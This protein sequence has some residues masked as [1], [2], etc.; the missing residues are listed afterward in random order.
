M[1]SQTLQ[2]LRQGVWAS[3]TGGWYY[4]PHQS[5]F[6]N[7]LHLYIWL[8]LLCFPFTLYMALPPTM[9]IV[10]I[11]C[12]VVAG[13]FLLLKT[14]NYRLHHAL[15]E[16]EVVEHRAKE[17]VSGASTEEANEGSTAT[18]QEDRNGPGDPGGGI[19]MADFIREETPPVD[20][21]SRNSY[22]GMDS[23]LQMAS[24]QGPRETITA[25]GGEEVG[26]RSDDCRLSL[27]QSS[28][29]VQDMMSDLKM[30]C[31]VSNHS[32]ASMQPSTSLGP[33]DL[34]HDPA[35]LCNSASHPISQSLS[36]CDTEVSGHAHGLLSQSVKAEPRTRGL[37][38]TSSSAGSA[39]P[40]PSQPSA[41][42][43]LY[44]PPRRGGL[45]PVCELEA[46]RPHRP[47][48]Q[49]GEPGG[50]EGSGAVKLHHR[51]DQPLASTSGCP[52][53]RY[54]HPQDLHRAGLAR[55]QSREAG[56]GGSGLY[57][58]DQGGGGRSGVG[59]GRGGGKVSADS[60]R[61]L[62][63]RSSGSTES[64]C[65]GTDR[66]TNSTISSFHS[67]Q[68]SS[69]HVESLLSLSGDEQRGTGALEGGNS[70]HGA[71]VDRGSPRGRSHV[72]S[73]GRSNVPSREANKNP[74]ANELTAKQSPSSATVSPNSVALTPDPDTSCSCNT[75]IPSR[76]PGN[77]PDRRVRG[78][79]DDTRPKSAN[80]VQRTSSS[81]GVAQTGGGSRRTGK[82]RASSFDASRHRDYMSLRGTAKP[83]SA[84]FAGGAA[85][86]EEWSDGSE[87]S[88]ASSLQSTMS[89]H[90]ST[91]SSS[92]TTSQSCH[93]PEGRYR[94][95][96]A[97]HSSRHAPTPSTSQKAPAVS[98]GGGGGGG[99]AGGGGR[100][101]SSR[102]NPSTGS[103]RTHARVLSLDSG[104]AAAACL[105]DPHRLGAPGTGARPLTTSKSDLEAK[106]GEVLDAASLL[107][108]AS[109]L[110]TVTRSRNSLPSQT[111][112]C[113]E[114][115]DGTN[116]GSSRAP[117]SEDAVTFRRERSTFRRQAVRRRHNAGS[118]PTPPSS[119]IGSP[120]SLQEALSQASQPSTSQLKGLP[121]RTPSQVTVL[122]ASA[123]LLARNGSAHL[124]GSQD[125]A[126]TVGTTSLQ[127]DFGKQT[128]S[129]YE[130]GGCDMSL[131][132]FEPATRRASNNLW[133]TDSHLSSATSVRVYPHDLIRLNRLLT[134]DPELLEQQDVDLSPELQDTPLGPEDPTTAAAR[135]AKHYYRLWLLP[136]LWV[137]L[138]FDRLT[139]LA[140]FDRNRELLENVLAVVLAV[141]VAFLGSILLVN[142]FFTDIWVFQFCL[143]IASCQYSLL[144]S[145]QPD[146]SS[147]RHGHNRIIAYSRPVY[148]CLCCGLIWALD[149]SSERTSSARITLYGV[150]L[151]SSLVLASARDLV[152]VFTLCFPVVFFVGLLPQ[153]NTFV[154][155]L[156]EQLDIHVFG[157]NASTSLLSSVYSVGR[158]VVTVAL[159][160]ALCYGALKETWEP[161]HIPVLFSVFCGLLVAVSYHLSRQSSDPSVLISL[162]QSKVL[163][164]LK[165]PNPEDPLSEVQ[166][167]L[168]E[169]L[170]GS[171]NERLH[172][173]LIVCVVIA[174]LYFA[175]HVSTMFI[176]LQPF[177]SYVLYSLLGAVGLLT[178]HVLP[179][180]RQQLPWYCFS[181][182]LLKTKEYYQFEVRGAAH[183]MWF[184]KLHVW[185]LFLEKNVLYPLVIL[186]EMSGSA[187]EL[188]S[189]RKL[190]TEVGAL[191]ITVAGLKLLRSSFSSPTYQYVTVLFTVLF[192]TFDYRDLSETL[193][194]DLFL[195]SIVFSK[196]WELFYKLRFVYTYI[197]PW[198]ITWGSAFH[199]FA[200]PFAVPHSA[201]LFVQAIISS[202]FSTPLNP[203]LGSAIFITSYVR[204][205]KFWE[206]D[207]NTK[208]VDHSNTRL[209]SQLDR[210]PGSD[211]NNL[212]SIFYEHLT[213]SLQHSLCGDLLLGRWGNYGTGDCFIL[214]SD[215]LNA[216]VHLVEI[217]NGL[218]TYQLRGLEFRGTYCQQ[219]EVEA[220]TEGVEEDESCCCCEPGHLPH[221]LSFNAAF[222]QRWL[223]WEVLVTKYVLEGYS[224]TDN[225]AASMLQVFDLRRILTTYYVKGI[226]YYV[227]ESARLDE[228]LANE[229]MR[230]GLKA[231]GERNYVDL[232]P[233]FNPNID[234]DYDHRLAG[235]SRDSFCQVYLAWIQY[236]NSR[237]AKPLDVEK[238][239]SL[240]LLCF[241][242]CVLGRRALGTAAHHMSS[243]LES[244][245]HGLH[246]LFKGD[247]R[248]S[249]VRDEWIF[250]D[251]ELLKKVV[252]PGIR[253]SLKLHQDHFTSPDE[254]D[255]PVVLFEAISSHQQNLVIAHEG[256]PAWRSAVLS[257]SPSLLALRHVLDEGTNEYKIIMLNRRYLS[258]RVI[259]VNKECVRGLWAG[260]QQ[261][262]VFFRNR[263]PERGSIQNAK[264]ALRNMINSS[265]DQPIGYPIY[266][267]P[268]TTSY[269]DSHT[270]LGHILGGPISMGNIR[271]FVVSTW[272]RLRK[273]CGAGCNSGGNI[274]DPDGGGVSCASGNGSGD[275]QPSSV[276]Q[277]GLSGTA[278]PL[279]HLPHTMG[280]D[281]GHGRHPHQ[282]WGTSQSSQSVQSGLV[283]H[284]P[285]RAS[286]AS[287][288][289]SYR[290]S[291][292]RHSSLRTSA[293]GL[294][295][296]RRSSTSQLSLRTLPT[297]LQLRLGSGSSSDPAGPSASLSSHSI[298]LC[299]RHTLVGLLGSDGLCG[300]VA[301]PLGQHLHQHQHNPTLVSV[302]RDDI[303]YRVQIMDVSQVLENINLSKRKELQ[304]PDETLRLRAGRSCWRDW[305]PLEGMEGHVIHRWVPCSRDLASRSHIDKTIL[306]VQVDDKLVPIIETGVIELGAE[307]GIEI[308]RTPAD[309][310]PSTLVLLG[311][312]LGLLVA[313]AF[314][315]QPPENGKNWVVIVAGSNGWYN[316]RHQADACHAYQIVHNNGVPDEQIVVMMYDDL[317]N[318]EENPTPGV[319][320]N[321]P[322]GTDVYKGVPKDYI[323]EAVTSQ[324]FLA[325]LKGESDSIKGGSGKVLKSG[326]NDHVFVYF[327]D[328]GA[329]GLLAFPDDELHVDDLQAT[330]QYMRQNK[331]YKKMVFYIE[332]C[333]SG[334]MMT[335]LPADID[336]YAT[337]ASNSRESSYACYYDEKR[338]T[339]LGD[340]YSV[341]WME[342]SD[343]EDLSKETLLKQFKIVK[344]HT[345]TSHVQQFGNKTL[346]HM[347]VMAFQGNARSNPPSRPVALQAVADPDLTPGPDVPLAIL[348]RKLM[349]TND[350]TTARTY[351][352]AINAELKV[353]EMLREATRSIVLKVT[354]DEALTQKIL[355]SQLDLTQ[356]QCYKAAVSHYKTHCFNW[357]TTQYEYALR[358]L[359]A[360]VNLCEEGYPTDRILVAMESVCQFN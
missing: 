127:D 261:E 329:P 251:M 297:S 143:V 282:A 211:D 352:G 166:D 102:R 257:N 308:T 302:R 174:V 233:T 79:K 219:R 77:D 351:L 240:V 37:P 114:P 59:G 86:E 98:E 117:G 26:K 20:C 325:V 246:A 343:V 224:I 152:I 171:V 36:S 57:Q 186:N 14:V 209:A 19:E 318:S 242:L 213:R 316:Y 235:I 72:P 346:A 184:E 267:S 200:Q 313:N 141:L 206:R 212:N 263:N 173:D 283:R 60:L 273:G 137:S 272:H 4:D 11:Y 230:E 3:I 41:E 311:L 29:Q 193:L 340:W 319:L 178:H 16:G 231:C 106:E 97:K 221:I 156:F 181:Q 168:P 252:V 23:G 290:Y 223:A 38:R 271:N 279:A 237:R 197:A 232:D 172:S 121:S 326:P 169:K 123:S 241:G 91:D 341:N 327:T 208:R 262:L 309:M 113:S 50:V 253:M 80:L 247:F 78:Q 116:T 159:L 118:N 220:I 84:V 348:K 334:S 95:L 87:L 18:R 201:M 301:D 238:D 49:A 147:P 92:S 195:M 243:N 226:I 285:A 182:P 89:Q 310:F 52:T 31:L 67:E 345:N 158:S 268:L 303:S 355:S 81:S 110:E 180:L 88:C 42:F 101:C 249:S 32:F 17:E 112:F 65:S 25:K 260:Q 167:P 349:K 7:A 294:E 217:G 293:T 338:D 69:T 284:S 85:G 54:K 250:A 304:W 155:Y 314:P 324:N 45:D 140:L 307:D 128:P 104:T 56:E 194:L 76:A 163:P 64:Y 136:Y 131:V 90:F 83:R 259:K 27:V 347:K 6:V 133:D 239:S 151:T 342:D 258:F 157:G 300:G 75:D 264:Q 328:H 229:T 218:V 292:S 34:S 138:H 58:V 130:A 295:P 13:L 289:S 10:G 82:K 244:F 216:L 122:S 5:T 170:R 53:D 144:K 322:N 333:E 61:S 274:E 108:R 286:V 146:S 350:I 270:Q 266:V 109:Q 175:I 198:Q 205:V 40:D 255:E 306:L 214:A 332:A 323:K 48:A 119:L 298:P 199:A 149:Y 191:M 28:S 161:Q 204:P 125:K 94:A 2:I 33:F 336:V 15:D 299:K 315:S 222:G 132:N 73:R 356:H 278:V 24:T 269:C 103:A 150:A 254:Y 354:G 185:L 183:V 154:M 176:V 135:K 63:T 207:Y 39:F 275:S 305:N 281:R 234:E 124:E 288:S 188:A 337:T 51:Q 339:Y 55:S 126:S 43:S 35:N 74:H 320:I 162:V 93:S 21:S 360:L 165:D 210:N 153:I 99:R 9:V 66:D 277:G 62:S 47:R 105:N 358:H 225:S 46:A 291:S 203:F 187:R 142:G 228:W 192:F 359:Y 22:T 129:L 344:Q 248:I 353:R 107:G 1:G 96:K 134:M 115:Q 287:Q 245:L 189:P 177:L 139:L 317:A 164:N 312:S 357:H 321:R 68:T 70:T 145:V 227:I 331:K 100:R 148:F 215:Y 12:G 160:Y 44:P 30:Y 280:E 202:V 111:A 335:N 8:F 330:I 265:C 236:C 256:D 190:N 276:S 296:C 120:L 71:C 196:L 179:Q